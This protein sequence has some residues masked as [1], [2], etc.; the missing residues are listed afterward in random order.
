MRSPK[1]REEIQEEYIKQRDLA[2]ARAELERHVEQLREGL[3]VGGEGTAMC[4]PRASI[5][6]LV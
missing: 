4:D 1:T 6:I 3:Y 5:T 2:T